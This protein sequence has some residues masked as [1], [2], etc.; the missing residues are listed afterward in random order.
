MSDLTAIDILMLPDDT[1]LSRA[2]DLNETMRGNNPESF[3][4]DSNHTP[5]MTLL[6]R[7]VRTAELDQVFAAV[8][9]AIGSVDPASLTLK[10]EHV[11]H[12]KLA[13]TPGFGLA[14]LVCQPGQGVLDLQEVLISAVKPFT[15]SGGTAAAY[16]T[17]DAEPDINSDTL[18]YIENYVPEHSGKN[19]LAHVTVGSAELD[20]LT[21]FEKKPFDT[22][23]FLVA[24]FAVYHLG[25]NGTA[26]HQL[27]HWDLGSTDGEAR[28]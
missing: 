4:L 5:H 28:Q 26:Q 24:G 1:M 19:F 12:M 23:D 22:F 6:Q 27:K 17:S 9:K 20:F 21:E 13:A 2:K 25:N 15:E 14:A 16:V 3:A 18:H 8:G 11:A 10:G 7:Y